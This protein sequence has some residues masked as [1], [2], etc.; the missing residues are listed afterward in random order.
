MKEKVNKLV[1]VTILHKTGKYK[2]PSDRY[3]VS[4]YILAG[5]CLGIIILIPAFALKISNSIIMYGY[6]ARNAP[7]A[8]QAIFYFPHFFSMEVIPLFVSAYLVKKYYSGDITVVVGVTLLFGCVVLLGAVISNPS[9]FY[10]R[11]I[12][13]TLCMCVV[14]YGS[15]L[16]YGTLPG[17]YG[18]TMYKILAL[19]AAGVA[20]ILLISFLID[21][22]F[23]NTIFMETGTP[24]ADVSG[25]ET[26]SATTEQGAVDTSNISS[27][28]A[29]S[30]PLI[31]TQQHPIDS[32]AAPAESNLHTASGRDWGKTARE[33][34][35]G[36]V[37]TAVATT[38]YTITAPLPEP[39]RLAV[40]GVGATIAAVA[41][42]KGEEIVTDLLVDVNH[43]ANLGPIPEGTGDSPTDFQEHPNT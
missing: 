13:Y 37:G 40:T 39:I 2:T 8:L 10:S 41:T 11:T 17:K 22:L 19:I 3:A 24:P 6:L 15:T 4:C 30:A 42:T 12:L 26:F 1:I 29:D 34:V 38:L 7:A 20:L 16:N 9:L 5:L 23:S 18:L 28:E 21:G 25:S 35:G 14:S 27:N 31:E 33:I 32:A 36:A 43:A